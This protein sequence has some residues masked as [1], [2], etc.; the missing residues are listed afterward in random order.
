M[1]TCTSRSFTHLSTQKGK[2]VQGES[3]KKVQ[4]QSTGVGTQ[5]RENNVDIPTLELFDGWKDE[6]G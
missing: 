1:F 4:H 2:E 6:D 3:G 5:D